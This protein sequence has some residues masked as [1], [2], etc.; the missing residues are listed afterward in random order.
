MLTVLR[1]TKSQFNLSYCL[2]KY[3]RIIIK[4]KE[5]RKCSPP[6]LGHFN[7]NVLQSVFER[8]IQVIQFNF[9]LC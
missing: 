5:L 2:S 4:K 8:G 3:T 1:K 6:L 9:I 7:L